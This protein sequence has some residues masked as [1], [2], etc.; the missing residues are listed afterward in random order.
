MQCSGFIFNVSLVTNSNTDATLVHLVAGI[1]PLFLWFLYLY[2][3]IR[4]AIMPKA[5][6]NVL[7]FHI[8]IYIQQ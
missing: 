8:I 6:K 3:I 5:T 4:K 7:T 2:G 1:Y